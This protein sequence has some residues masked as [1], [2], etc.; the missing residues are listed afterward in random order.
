MKTRKIRENIFWL[1]AIDWDR[2][3]FDSLIPLPDGTSYNAYL[4]RG[5]QKTVLVDSVDPTMVDVLLAQVEEVPQIDFVISHHAEQDHSGAIPH[6]LKKYERA[7]VLATPQAKGML[8]DLLGIPEEKIVTVKDGERLSL[9]GKTLEFIHTPWVHWPE[10]MVTYLLEDKI[11]F[12]CDFFGSHIATTDLFVRDEGRVYEAAKRYYAEIMMPFRNVIQKN[13]EKLGGHEIDLIAPS[14]GP[15]Y[16]KPEFIFQAYRD[17]VSENPKNIVV[18]PYISMHGSTE[19][20]VRYLV[21]ALAARGIEVY[22]FNLAATDIGKLAI[23]LVDAATIV[24]GTPTVHAGPHPLVFYAASLANLLRPKAKFA[25]VIGSYGWHSKA[26][27]QIAGLIPNLKVEIL[28]PVLGKGYPKEAEFKALD[29]LAG[30]I[31]KKH[32][33]ANLI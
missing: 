24:L 30:T 6:V 23:S 26:I 16:D 13:L 2:R 28:N 12:S 15:V 29:D 4:V 7:K 20:M 31:H 14:H 22:Q 9:G 17:W 27:E 33:E 19:Q 10:T 1:G 11:L 5:S 21:S 8:Q 3:L 25:S 18:I 32:R